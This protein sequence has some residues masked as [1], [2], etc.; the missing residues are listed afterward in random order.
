LSHPT[1]ER[2]VD[3]LSNVL[4]EKLKEFHAKEYG[5]C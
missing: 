4:E 3:F 2:D 5:I 1:T